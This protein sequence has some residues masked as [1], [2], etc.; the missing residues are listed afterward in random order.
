MAKSLFTYESYKTYLRDSIKMAPR[1]G[2]GYRQKLAEAMEIQPTYLSQ[3][4]K[5]NR[6][7]SLD[8][9]ILL[10]EFLLL[11]KDESEYL[12]LLI[13]HERAG[14]A[15]S[16]RFFERL[17]ENR[18]ERFS[19]VKNRVKISG[20][21]TDEDKATYYS[22]VLYGAVHM[23]VTIPTLRSIQALATQLKATPERVRDVA[24]FLI[25]KN[26]VEQRGG[27]FYP[28]TTLLFVDKSSPHVVSH[29]RNWRLKALEKAASRA[30]TDYHVSLGITLSEKDANFIRQKLAQMIEEIAQQVKESPEEK[31]MGFC[32]DFFDY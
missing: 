25:E 26:L 4:L 21:L 20:E 30:P 8:Q 12:L 32:L 27:L 29:H 13:N 28:G 5:G 6:D 23:A 15:K 1:G 31:L 18:R 24:N 19:R 17:L 16:E 11:S 10:S 14:S 9:G 2:H 22:D 3:V 7:L